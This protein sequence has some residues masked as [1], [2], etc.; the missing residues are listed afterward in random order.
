[1]EVKSESNS[2]KKSKKIEIYSKKSTF[3]KI[4]NNSNDIFERS[5]NNLISSY[6]SQFISNNNSQNILVK[7]NK[8]STSNGRKKSHHKKKAIKVK[9]TEDED[10]YY[11]NIFESLDN[12]NI[13]ILDSKEAAEF[14]KKSGLS[15]N[16]L[17][18]IW[19]IAS[20]SSISFIERNEFF[21][22][23]RLIALAQNNFP[24]NE[25]SVEKNTPLPPLPH[26]KYKI[27]ADNERIIYKMSQNNKIKYQKLF[28]DSKENNFDYNIS[29][30]KALILWKTMN[31]ED[32]L[33]K[34]IA[35]LLN[36]LE[37]KG[38]L[39]LK[40]FQVGSYIIQIND[41]YEIPSKL[42]LSL[43]NYL[44]RNANIIHNEDKKVY[45]PN[46][47][48]IDNSID[49]LNEKNS[50]NIDEKH[51]N[52]NMAD[53]SKNLYKKFNEEDYSLYIVEIMKR[54]DK[55]KKE[56]NIVDEKLSLA[57]NKMNYLFEEINGLQKQRNLIQ[58]KLIF[59]NR[60][61]L[62]IIDIIAKNK[63]IIFSNYSYKSNDNIDI[64]KK[65][66]FFDDKN[67][68]KHYNSACGSSS[69]KKI[70]DNNSELFNDINI[71]KYLEFNKKDILKKNK[72]NYD[73]GKNKN[74][75]NKMNQN[76]DTK[77]KICNKSNV[78]KIDSNSNSLKK[79]KFEN[80]KNKSKTLQN[81]KQVLDKFY[82]EKEDNI[83]TN[84]NSKL[85]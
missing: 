17:K 42:P 41:K 85:S 30:T 51:I 19:L 57:K 37:Q 28:D 24:Y 7:H 80:Y 8:K 73:I 20:K 2:N 69:N 76:K 54:I 18:T 1:M 53:I 32:D 12:K 77:K 4:R 5:N 71:N 3:M 23:L 52:E 55:L 39:N 68:Q 63:N 36:P 27:A 58:E 70:V 47:I 82:E 81:N 13:G 33:I 46:N 22:A 38:F 83:N 61:C 59:I 21:V 45:N 29:V 43:Y 78:I 9:L 65:I 16:I 26:F 11:N 62:N 44:G 84:V 40:E 6:N 64:I 56:N 25:E 79:D 34:K 49:N 14:L 35:G 74:I 31:A 50:I 60:E 66:H 10:I 72:S 75:V 67:I 15:R 48:V